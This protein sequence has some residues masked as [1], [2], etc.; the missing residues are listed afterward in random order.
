MSQ[1]TP[2]KVTGFKSV[3][4]KIEDGTITQLDIGA[5]HIVYLS[6]SGNVYISGMLK[7]CDSGVWR[8]PD[9][10]KEHGAADNYGVKGCHETPVHIP[11]LKNNTIAVFAGDSFCAALT[12]DRELYT[13]GAYRVRMQRLAC[14]YSRHGNV[15]TLTDLISCIHEC[16]RIRKQR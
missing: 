12:A 16:N 5:A 1:A 13:W 14:G 15:C 2:A 4:G 6:M 10:R 7:D 11:E 3:D 8:N 9:P